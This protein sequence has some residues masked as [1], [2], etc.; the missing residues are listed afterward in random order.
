METKCPNCP[1][2]AIPEGQFFEK[3][4]NVPINILK[5]IFKLRVVI[6]LKL[7]YCPSCG[8]LKLQVLRVR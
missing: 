1:E 8:H 2:K 4:L 6:T 5:F 7:S 3:V